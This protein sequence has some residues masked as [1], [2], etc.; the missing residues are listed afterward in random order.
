MSQKPYY[1][2]RVTKENCWQPP[3]A[4]LVVVDGF[5]TGSPAEELHRQGLLEIGDVI[6]QVWSHDAHRMPHAHTIGHMQV[7]TRELVGEGASTMDFAD[8]G[9]L[10]STQAD[11]RRS[12]GGAGMVTIVVSRS[13]AVTDELRRFPDTYTSNTVAPQVSSALLDV[14]C[15]HASVWYDVP[16]THAYAHV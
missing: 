5:F 13:R 10:F 11:D 4:E 9:K 7:G 14:T 16:C 3:P 1:H 12:S 6:I 8:V 15:I 2:N